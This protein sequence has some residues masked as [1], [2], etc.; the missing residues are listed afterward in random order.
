MEYSKDSFD[1]PLFI[2]GFFQEQHNPD[3]SD[4]EGHLLTQEELNQQNQIEE[5]E[6]KVMDEKIKIREYAFSST[7]ANFV[8]PNFNY[9]IDFIMSHLSL[10]TGRTILELGTGT[11]IVPIF[12]RKKGLVVVSSDYDAPEITNNI[13]YNCKLNKILHSHIPHVWGTPFNFEQLQAERVRLE[14][15]LQTTAAPQLDIVI[16][17]DILLYADQYPNLVNTLCQLLKPN[18]NAAR[19]TFTLDGEQ[20]HYPF[21]LLNVARRLDT[22]PTFYKL[23]TEAGLVIKKKGKMVIITQA[24]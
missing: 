17:T 23:A 18:N 21:F 3:S 19:E 13:D 4:D 20:Y 11:G 6:F 1:P 24:S 9:Q 7:N 10:F 16:A 22:T 15:A 2:S 12:L 5:K 8:W 14:Q